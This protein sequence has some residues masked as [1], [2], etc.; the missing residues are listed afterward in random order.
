MCGEGSSE[1]I[2]NN[3]KKYIPKFL[4]L[5]GESNTHPDVCTEE[6]DFKI[7]RILDK[8]LRSSGPTAKLPAVYEVAFYLC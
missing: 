1:V 6:M 4:E 2:R 5:D 8:K 3:W 7:L